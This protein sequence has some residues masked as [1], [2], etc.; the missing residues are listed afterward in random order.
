M[1]EHTAMRWFLGLALAV[2]VSACASG[3]PGPLPASFAPTHRVAAARGHLVLRI[4]IPRKHRHHGHYVSPATQSIAITVTPNTG[5]A[6]HFNADLTPATNP[7]CTPTL[8]CTIS[9]PLAPGTYAAAFAT[10]DGSL[11][12]GNA[13]TNPPTGN[14]L[15]ADGKVP[16]ALKAGTNTIVKVVLGGIP[17]RAAIVSYADNGFTFSKCMSTASV[18]V[19]G[20]DADNNIIIGPGAPSVALASGD[21]THLAVIATPPPSSPNTFVLSRPNIPEPGY[22]VTLT[23]TVTPES[24]SGATPVNAKATATFNADVCGTFT[25]YPIPTTDSLP[26]LGIVAG[27]DGAVWF[28]EYRGNNIGRITTTGSITEFSVAPNVEPDGLAVDSVGNLWFTEHANDAVVRMTTGG[29]Q[30]SN[31]YVGASGSGPFGIA[32]G[33]DGRT[34]LVLQNTNKIVNIVD[35]GGGTSVYIEDTPAGSNPMDIASGPDGNLWFTEVTTNKIGRAIPTSTFPTLAEFDIPTIDASPYA[36]AAGPDGALWFTENAGNN[37]G[38]ITTSGT[39]TEF[40]IPTAASQPD[41]ITSGPDGA[42]WFVENAANK[43]GRIATEGTIT[44]FTITGTTGSNPIGITT[45]PDRN[46]WF[47]ESGSNQIGELQ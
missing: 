6:M 11:A 30:S 8:A 1:Q 44:E 17:A 28:T 37:I 35:N 34:Y 33:A 42:L 45:G 41:G 7:N 5:P 13:F 12:G 38:R 15:S 18:G 27:A 25:H 16:I 19:F 23:A 14:K 4:A 43:I 26:Y 29:T 39:I 40:S 31:I 10:Y 36:I 9:F 2:S 24:A 46:I 21:T 32:V 3:A 22:S 20:F 47:T